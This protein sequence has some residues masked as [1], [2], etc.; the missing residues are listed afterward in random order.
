MNHFLLPIAGGLLIGFASA[1]LLL[2]RG[3]IAGISGILWG[4]LATTGS[5]KFWRWLFLLGLIIG[6]A[7]YHWISGAPVPSSNS[8][9]ISAIVGGLIV[10]IGTKLGSG[11]TSGHGVCGIGRLSMRS[12]V[13]TC[14]FM[15][16][17]I[18]TVYLLRHVF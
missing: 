10:G 11:C 13:A 14:I 5:D 3:K 17:G 12:I 1:L 7:L 15:V 6:A 18:L 2:F 16:T 9:L 4:A 8:S